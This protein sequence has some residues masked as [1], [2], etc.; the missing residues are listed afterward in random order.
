[1]KRQEFITLAGSMA[2]AWPLAA[3]A[4]QQAQM[5]RVGVLVSAESRQTSKPVSRCSRKSYVS[6]VGS[7]ATMCGSKSDGLA[8]IPRRLAKTRKN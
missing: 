3:H 6:W 5:R 4:Q 1:M 7:T 8:L 2:V